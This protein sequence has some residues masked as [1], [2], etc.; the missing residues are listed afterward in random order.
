MKDETKLRTG[1]KNYHDRVFEEEIVEH[2]NITKHH[3][4]KYVHLSLRS[5]PPGLICSLLARRSRTH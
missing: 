3:F 2:I 4:D 5:S 1:P